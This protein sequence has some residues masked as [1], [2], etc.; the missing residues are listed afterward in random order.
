[1]ALAMP[2]SASIVYLRTLRFFF[3]QMLAESQSA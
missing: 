2:R 1:M 3:D